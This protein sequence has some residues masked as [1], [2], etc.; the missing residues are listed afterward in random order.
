MPM[1]SIQQC[2]NPGCGMNTFKISQRL[3]RDKPG[4]PGLKGNGPKAEGIWRWYGV[5]SSCGLTGEI[6]G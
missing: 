4:T 5:C 1:E 6:G 2:P 3:V